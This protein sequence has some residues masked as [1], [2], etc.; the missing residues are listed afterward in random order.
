MRKIMENQMQLGE[1][2][3]SAIE[4]DLR[5]RD[6]IPKLL[7]GLQHI[8][9]NTKLRNQVFE[10]LEQIVP[11]GVNV[12]NGRPGMYLWRI[13]V[14]GTL[15]LSCNWD[16]DRLRE[17]TNNHKKIRKMLGHGLKDKDYIYSLQTLKDN[18]SLFTLEV[19]DKINQVVV[20]A[21]QDFLGKKKDEELKGRCDSFVVET[22]VHYPTDI[23]LLL[24]AMRKVLTLTAVACRKVGVLGWRQ[25]KHNL[26][27]VKKLFHRAQKTYRSKPKSEAKKTQKEQLIKE[28]QIAYLDMVRSFIPKVKETLITLRMQTEISDDNIQTIEHYLSHAERQIS[29]IERR[30]LNGEVIPHDEKVFSIFEEYTE[31]ISKGK[32]GVPQELGLRVC[33]LEDQ[34]GFILHHLVMEKETDDKVAVPITQGAKERFP[35]LS[36]CSYDKGFYSP[37]NKKELPKIINRITL[38]KKGRLSLKDKELEFSEEFIQSRHQH[39]AVESAINALEYHSLDRCPDRGIDGFKRYVALAVLARNIQILGNKVQQKELKKLK[40]RYK[41]AA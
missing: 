31:W 32:A 18:I 28:A 35:A 15:R 17:M 33:I 4:F 26:K 3:I 36:S 9:C 12:N 10:I 27:K 21:G 6:D 1:V 34:Y 13:L 39:S 41:Q 16:Y 5:S 19:L 14:L 29:Q 23:N 2:D 38:P 22:N 30:V 37:N 11:E 25:S 24:D 20:A 40:Q 7:M 8:Y